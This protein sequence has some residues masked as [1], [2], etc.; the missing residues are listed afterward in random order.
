[1]C[2]KPRKPAAT[3]TPCQ[4][5]DLA[6]WPCVKAFLTLE[7]TAT[8]YYDLVNGSYYFTNT[9]GEDSFLPQAYSRLK[10][11]MSNSVNQFPFPGWNGD[12]GILIVCGRIVDTQGD[13]GAYLLSGTGNNN[14]RV[15]TQYT[16]FG[17]IASTASLKWAT[18]FNTDYTHPLTLGTDYISA[19]G[20]SADRLF[21]IADDLTMKTADASVLLDTVD[22]GSSNPASVQTNMA[23]VYSEFYA[24]AGDIISQ[25]SQLGH[26][27]VGD[28][29][30]NAFDTAYGDGEFAGMPHE[31]TRAGPVYERVSNFV[32]GAP[33]ATSQDYAGILWC[34][35]ADGAPSDSVLQA[36]VAW[37][38]QAWTRGIKLPPPHF[39]GLR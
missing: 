30:T 10:G 34:R 19:G 24:D 27:G 28:I 22:P 12:D 38:K 1:M 29:E 18:A 15:H 21:H 2:A 23:S 8:P 16:V 31:V 4:V 25:F 6:A 20:K 32:G 35:F 11:V 36:A 17:T 39:R 7:E 3:L 14:L 26:G 9:T 5:A 37:C 13:V 33:A